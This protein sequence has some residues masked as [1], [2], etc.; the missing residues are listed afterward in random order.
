MFRPF[1]IATL[2]I[3]TCSLLSVTAQADSASETVTAMTHAN[4]AAAAADING[5]H[6]H[7][8][9]ALNCLVGPNGS[10]FDAKE[11]NPCANAGRGAIPD[12]TDAA[13]KKS[14]AAAADKLR[15]GIASSDLKTAQQAA[16]DAATMLKA[17]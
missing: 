10:G 4:L 16:T 7:Q 2:A 17:K 9:H 5:V 15:A 12:A 3:A 6:M 8:H 11:L 1:A 13:K 14:L